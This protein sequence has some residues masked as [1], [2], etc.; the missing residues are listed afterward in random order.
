[1]KL[2]VPNG[3]QKESSAA[4]SGILEDKQFYCEL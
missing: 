3:W 1:M 4:K 2:A